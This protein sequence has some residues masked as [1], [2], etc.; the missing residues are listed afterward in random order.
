MKKR[1]LTLLE[2]MIV[3]FLI[4]LITGAIGYNMRGTLDRGRVFRTEQAKEQLRDLLLICLAENP[5]AE[6]IA[7]KPVYYLKK[8]GL[9]KDP[10]NLIKDGWKKEFS[11]KATKDKS[12]FD[13]RSEALD[14]YK[15]K[16]GILDETSDEE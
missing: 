6:A 14:A 2:I 12:D 16:K 11:I 7:K 15:K 9:A 13:I 3:I 10:E 5:D 1:T 4:T 8:T